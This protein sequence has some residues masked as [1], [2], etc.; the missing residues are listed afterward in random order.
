[1][2]VIGLAG[3]AA[4]FF[5]GRQARERLKIERRQRDARNPS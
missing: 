5:V 1:M 2:T 3:L 4:M